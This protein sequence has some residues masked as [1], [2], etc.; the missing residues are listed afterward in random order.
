[1]NKF[2]KVSSFKKTNVVMK[3]G[4]PAFHG[5]AATGS[6][7]GVEFVIV[8]P[9]AVSC[10]EIWNLVMQIPLDR[11]G[12]QKIVMSRKKDIEMEIV[13]EAPK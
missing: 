13:K 8:C 3:K 4:I 12:L 5:L 9:D 10:E 7:S 11:K 1:M 2:P 6:I